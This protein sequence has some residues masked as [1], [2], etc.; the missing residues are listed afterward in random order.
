VETEINAL[1]YTQ[2]LLNG[3]MTS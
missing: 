1:Q 3:V 2:A